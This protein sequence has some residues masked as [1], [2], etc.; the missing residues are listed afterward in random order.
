MILFSISKLNTQVYLN[1][2]CALNTLECLSKISS[3]MIKNLKNIIIL[4]LWANT[5]NESSVKI[6]GAKIGKWMVIT[7]ISIVR[8]L[9]KFLECL[10]MAKWTKILKINWSIVDPQDNE[11]KIMSWNGAGETSLPWIM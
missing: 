10:Q 3:G 2:D 6:K 9:S 7:R 5:I 8:S 4:H 11:A 1:Q